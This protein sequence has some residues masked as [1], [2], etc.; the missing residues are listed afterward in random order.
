M[1]EDILQF[2]GGKYQKKGGSRIQRGSEPKRNGELLL[3]QASTSRMRRS[4]G[5]GE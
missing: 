3:K 2:G 1:K 4:E 5:D